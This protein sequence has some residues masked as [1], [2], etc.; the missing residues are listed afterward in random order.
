M[1]AILTAS[2]WDRP[3]DSGHF[4]GKRAGDDIGVMASQQRL[5]P[6]TERIG[7]P[8]D[9][10]HVPSRLKMPSSVARPPIECSPGTR[11]SDA[12]K[13]RPHLNP[14]TRPA[15]A[16]RLLTVIGP[17]PRMVS[18]RWPASFPANCRLSSL[19]SSA[20]SVLRYV[21]LTQQQVPPSAGAVHKPDHQAGKGRRADR[22]AHAKLGQKGINLIPRRRALPPPAQGLLLGRL[23]G[24]KAHRRTRGGFADRLSAGGVS[25]V[26][27]DERFDEL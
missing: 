27:L 22:Q 13:S 21:A 19:S 16:S 20:I 6:C 1:C 3:H 4:N 18:N 8:V 12:A 24:D 11:P 10:A 23:D 26:A 14:R 25:L 2:G 15:I 9:A 5:R 17:M 7:T